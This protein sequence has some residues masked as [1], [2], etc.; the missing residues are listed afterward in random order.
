MDSALATTEYER[1]RGGLARTIR[2]RRSDCPPYELARQ[3]LGYDHPEHT[4][5]VGIDVDGTRAVLFHERDRYGIAVSFGPN[6]LPHGG[7][8]IAG[9]E[10]GPG[11]DT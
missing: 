4:A 11:I 3:F 8:K 7:A 9:F 10:D 6:G 2:N 5:L 1:T